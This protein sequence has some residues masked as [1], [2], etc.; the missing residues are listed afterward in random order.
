MKRG[1]QLAA[2]AAIVLLAFFGSYGVAAPAR[3]SEKSANS[4]PQEFMEG[5]CKSGSGVVVFV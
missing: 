5:Y 2:R 3:A 4:C 1:K